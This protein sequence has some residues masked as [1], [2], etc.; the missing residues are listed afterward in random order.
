MN[1]NEEAGSSL[2]HSNRPTRS[3][4]PGGVDSTAQPNR[5]ARRAALA[6]AMEPGRVVS[7]SEHVA[8][9][10]ARLSEQLLAENDQEAGA[11]AWGDRGG[12]A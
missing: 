4:S 5:N 7:F 2:V 9:L 10:R 8:G 11:R 1:R 3:K 6:E 12:A